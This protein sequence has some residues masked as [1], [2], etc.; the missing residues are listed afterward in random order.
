MKH[1][2]R[3]RHIE[4]HIERRIGDL[5]VLID[6][7]EMV[8]FGSMSQQDLAKLEHLKHCLSQVVPI[9]SSLNSCRLRMQAKV[10][11]MAKELNDIKLEVAMLRGHDGLVR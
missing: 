4:K 10:D 2:A 9:V 3:E 5:G 6:T 7:Q 1:R 11:E 8:E